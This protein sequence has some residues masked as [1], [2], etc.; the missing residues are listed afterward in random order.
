MIRKGV[1]KYCCEDI[2]LIENYELAISDQTQYWECHHRKETDEG[3]SANELIE[4]GLYFN[5]PAS[6]LIFL[7]KSEHN[8]IHKKGKPLSTDHK[9]KLSIALK[10]NK[11]RLGK[12]HTTETKEKQSAS[13]KGKCCGK[14]NPM[15]NAGDKHPKARA[16]YQ[17]D[18]SSGKIIKRWS[19]IKYAA[20][21]LG[22]RQNSI[23]ACCRG[24]HKT[25]GGFIWRYAD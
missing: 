3:L 22:I 7:T 2:S 11:N 16:V 20:N 24:F 13:R 17:I 21:E 8:S 23:S 18:K 12:Q 15:Y 14:N 4:M 6:E 19:C 9:S 1:E 5:R 10:N 25:A